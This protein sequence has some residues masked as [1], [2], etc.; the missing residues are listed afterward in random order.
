MSVNKNQ[1]QMP[2]ITIWFS[3]TYKRRS[4]SFQKTAFQ[5]VKG[6]LLEHKRPPFTNTSGPTATVEGV[7][8]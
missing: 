1:F 8:K 4:F 3:T 2:H 5:R 7:S 6:N